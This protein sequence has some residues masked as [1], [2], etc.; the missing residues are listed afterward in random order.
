MA[1]DSVFHLARQIEAI[2]IK[3]VGGLGGWL[4]LVVSMWWDVVDSEKEEGLL[5]WHLRCEQEW[6]E[7]VSSRCRLVV[8]GI[9][10]LDTKCCAM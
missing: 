2:A 6:S 3:Q 5:V 7:A 8:A 10:I 1:R 9:L 4:A